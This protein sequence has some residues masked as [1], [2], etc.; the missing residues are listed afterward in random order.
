MR[1]TA[2]HQMTT[3]YV[4][5][6]ATAGR[7]RSVSTRAQ[8]AANALASVRLEGLVPSA[9]MRELAAAW[10]RGEATDENLLAAEQRLLADARAA[11]VA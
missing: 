9:E 4:Q 11:R 7:M 6:A 5:R 8:I 1:A 10:A 3:Q 2:E